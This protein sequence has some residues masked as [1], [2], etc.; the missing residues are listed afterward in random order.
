M[1]YAPATLANAVEPA[2]VRIQVATA[3]C[4]RVVSLNSFEYERLSGITRNQLGLNVGGARVVC[5]GQPDTKSITM[6]PQIIQLSHWQMA[7]SRPADR[8]ES[9]C[10]Q[11]VV[12][13]ILWRHG[14]R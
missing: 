11:S 3:P 2:V 12:A 6:I 8:Q 4:F 14:V 9:G 10:D 1:V 7:S 13:S 5:Q